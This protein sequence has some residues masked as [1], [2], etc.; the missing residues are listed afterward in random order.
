MKYLMILVLIL[1]TA[2]S[3]MSQNAARNIVDGNTAYRNNE[4]EKAAGLYRKSME[5][6]SQY[7]FQAKYNLANTLYKSGDYQGAREMYSSLLSDS[8]NSET[9]SRLYHNI[10]N[11]FMQ[12]KNYEQGVSAYANALKLNPMDEDSRYNLS[13]A[14]KMLKK[15]QQQQQQQNKD[16]NQNKDQEKQNQDQN[17][18]D[19]NKDKQDQNKQ[20]QNKDKQGQDK[21]KQDQDKSQD[22]QN[23]NK[24]QNQDKTQG[25]N[26]LS[27][28]QADKML[29]ALQNKE[30]QTLREVHAGQ[31][32]GTSAGSNTKDW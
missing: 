12:E 15:Q 16:Q 17:K 28:A 11:T 19:S 18:Q 31:E 5:Q 25:K 2:I 10:G 30:K 1:N 4:F 24:D 27:P 8:L 3:A 7:G 22:K 32:D 26:E 20:D 6:Q 9:Q 29:K 23:Q 13:Y 21:D 14:L